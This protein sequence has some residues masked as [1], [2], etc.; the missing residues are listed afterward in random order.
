MGLGASVG[1][2]WGLL[3]GDGRVCG[4]WESREGLWGLWGLWRGLCGAW[5]GVWCFRALILLYLFA[6]LHPLSAAPPRAPAPPPGTVGIGLRR[7]LRTAAGSR[8]PPQHGETFLD[9]A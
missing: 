7:A 2:S 3:W 4:S 8:P 5:K 1:G 9:T 6:H